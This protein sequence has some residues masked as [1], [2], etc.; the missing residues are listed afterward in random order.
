L[1]TV[2][3]GLH[4]FCLATCDP[5]SLASELDLSWVLSSRQLQ[6]GACGQHV[7]DSK[8]CGDEPRDFLIS[9]ELNR[10]SYRTMCRKESAPKRVFFRV[11]YRHSLS[12]LGK[13][14]FTT[15]ATIT[16]P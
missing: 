16:K 11:E 12:A 8:A 3:S 10:V 6:A 14:T 4:P 13:S 2:E 7:K 1:L 9:V 5:S 15:T